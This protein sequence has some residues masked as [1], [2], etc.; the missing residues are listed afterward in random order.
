MVSVIF[1]FVFLNIKHKKKL[2]FL[3]IWKKT[4]RIKKEKQKVFTTII[5]DVKKMMAWC[6]LRT[7]E[8]TEISTYVQQKKNKLFIFILLVLL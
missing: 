2:A 4:R 8:L 1:Y 5:C 6:L 3:T 7:A